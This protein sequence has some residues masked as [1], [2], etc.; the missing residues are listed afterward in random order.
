MTSLL[1][2][3]AT[4]LERAVEMLIGA[5]IDDIRV[6]LRDLWSAEDC[7]EELL[8]WLAWALS[9]D[10]WDP[11]WPNNIRRARVGAAIAIQRIKGSAQ[12]IRDVV[13]SFGGNVELREWFATTPPGIPHTFNLLVAL[14]GQSAE[15]PSAEFIE[16][17]IAEVSR[18]KPARSHFD[19]VLA[20]PMR[21]TIG[22]R[23]VA[24]PMVFARL[25]LSAPEGPPHAVA[26]PLG[27]L[28]AIT[29]TPSG[30]DPSPAA[31]PLGLLLSLTKAP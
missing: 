30:F 26:T 15:V 18:T 31:T 22:M 11:A 19:F 4:D 20:V 12:S 16:A 13:A 29:K 9:I 21:G 8:P 27:L 14:G 28:L 3:N 24:R 17:V 23:A 25:D 7:P 5:R 1:P 6:P 2:P 10:Q